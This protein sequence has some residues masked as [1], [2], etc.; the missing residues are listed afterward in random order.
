MDP[1]RFSKHALRQMKERG[2]T[3]DEVNRVLA[4]GSH[5]IGS[6]PGTTDHTAR[7]RRRTTVVVTSSRSGRVVTVIVRA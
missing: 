6:R 3:V 5:R 1:T 7:I 2:V 4:L